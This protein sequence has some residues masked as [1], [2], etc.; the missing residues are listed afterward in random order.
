MDFF[1]FYQF[2]LK[3]V[4][5]NGCGGSLIAPGVVLSAA[6]CA[7]NYVGSSVIVGGYQSGQVTGNAEQVNVLEEAIHPNYSSSTLANDIMLLRLEETVSM[8]NT[9]IKLSVNEDSFLPRMVRTSQ[10]LG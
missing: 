7:G 1:L 6:H 9:N 2:F 10:Y 5:M 8:S 4:D 3:S